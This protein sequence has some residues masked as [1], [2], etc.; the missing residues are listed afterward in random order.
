MLEGLTSRWMIFFSARYSRAEVTWAVQIRSGKGEGR[1]PLWLLRKQYL[2]W[3][4]CYSVSQE[5][6]RLTNSQE[7]TRIIPRHPCTPLHKTQSHLQ[8]THQRMWR[9]WD[10]SS[11]SRFWARS[12]SVEAA[13]PW[14]LPQRRLRIG[15]VSKPWPCLTVCE[16]L[17]ARFH[18]A[19]GRSVRGIRIVYS[20][21][22]RSRAMPFWRLCRS[23]R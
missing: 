23:L 20:R 9:Y 17:Y 6:S 12:R 14:S 19:R 16:S 4:H 15:F 22:C 8:R 11:H 2:L 10:V 5:T 3:Y 21:G 13:K 1:L 7:A 18:T